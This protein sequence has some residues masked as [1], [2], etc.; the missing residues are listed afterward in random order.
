M[1]SDW[2]IFTI[3]APTGLKGIEFNT[4][5]RLSRQNDNGGFSFVNLTMDVR[6]A[7]GGTNPRALLQ[8]ILQIP[9]STAGL[10][11]DGSTWQRP[12]DLTSPLA[13][14]E[15]DWLIQSQSN[16]SI[17]FRHNNPAITFPRNYGIPSG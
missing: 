15:T 10:A 17:T 4:G 9:L 8:M 2:K 14:S 7:Y 11:I 13:N 1:D 12:G 3:E 6:I 16:G 5:V